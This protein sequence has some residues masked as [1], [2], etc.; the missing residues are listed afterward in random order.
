[1]KVVSKISW[2]N[3]IH[4]IDIFLLCALTKS[5]L[6]H[7]ANFVK[8]WLFSSFAKLILGR[9]KRTCF[10]PAQH[11]VLFWMKLLYSACRNVK[12]GTIY[13]LHGY[14]CCLFYISNYTVTSIGFGSIFSLLLILT[15]NS[16]ISY[17]IWLY[18]CFDFPPF[19]VFSGTFL[20]F[21]LAMHLLLRLDACCTSK[22][23]LRI[24]HCWVNSMIN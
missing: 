16:S 7:A 18:F 20:L 23:M 9:K 1:M 6:G 15:V 14:K 17:N 4:C 11:T 12:F 5:V 13:L 10:I 2:G 24:Y 21:L 19:K 8:K 22:K 3:Y